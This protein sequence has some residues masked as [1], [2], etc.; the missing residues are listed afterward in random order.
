MFDPL[1]VVQNLMGLEII[2]SVLYYNLWYEIA[3]SLFLN[4]ESGFVIDITMDKL[5]PQG[6]VGTFT[7]M[8]KYPNIHRM[9]IA[10]SLATWPEYNSEEKL[11]VLM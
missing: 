4:S 3:T 1:T 9:I 6:S 7:G 2:D 5:S 10:S 11:E 8:S